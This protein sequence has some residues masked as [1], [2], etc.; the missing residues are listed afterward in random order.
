MSDE[1]KAYFFW[2]A[3]VL[4]IVFVAAP[5]LWKWWTG[6]KPTRQAR[7]E[8][9]AGAA[10]EYLCYLRSKLP[11]QATTSDF[12]VRC[13]EHEEITVE[14]ALRELVVMPHTNLPKERPK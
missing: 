9:L 12:L 3:V 7:P 14:D 11:E 1:A 6:W 2:A 5:Y 10:S 13:L 8:Q 4:L